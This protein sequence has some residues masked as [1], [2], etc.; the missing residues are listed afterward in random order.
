MLLVLQ[1]GTAR[2]LGVETGISV[3]TSLVELV[4]V[5]QTVLMPMITLQRLL[6][7]IGV[8]FQLSPLASGAHCLISGGLKAIS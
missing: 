1:E 8:L 3:N 4:F 5:V 6:L 7:P 2:V